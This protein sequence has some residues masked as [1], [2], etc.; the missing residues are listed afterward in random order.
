M[1][2]FRSQEEL[3]E[4]VGGFFKQMPALSVLLKNIIDGDDSLLAIDLSHPSLVLSV[5]CGKEPL[6]VQIGSDVPGTLCI[7]A[8]ADLF[9][10]LLL[11]HYDLL[12]AWSA[13]KLVVRGPLS[14][15]LKNS[16]LFYLAPYQYPLYLRYIGRDDLLAGGDRLR[17]EVVRG[18]GRFGKY[19]LKIMQFAGRLLGLCLRRNPRAFDVFKL[20]KRT[21]PLLIGL[22]A[23]L[24]KLGARD[25]KL[26]LALKAL[27]LGMT[28]AAMRET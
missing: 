21:G 23:L 6:E 12:K 27:G 11:G 9:H 14:R 5:D 16:N 2:Y 8:E 25:L 24:R 1:P 17:N 28:R 22:T 20:L 10:E 15:M 19:V 7:S 3:E 4:I 18:G 13:K 26:V